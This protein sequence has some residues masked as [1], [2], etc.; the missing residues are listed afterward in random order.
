[1]RAW[2]SLKW[3]ITNL[4]LALQ[5]CVNDVAIARHTEMTQPSKMSNDL[6]KGEWSYVLKRSGSSSATSRS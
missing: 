5:T 6:E 4:V 2:K 3:R 1:M